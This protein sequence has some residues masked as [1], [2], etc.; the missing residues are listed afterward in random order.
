MSYKQFISG[1]CPLKQYEREIQVTVS[2]VSAVGS[3]CCQKRITEFQCPDGVTC[4]YR[5]G[6]QFCDLVNKL[7]L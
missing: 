7:H 4:P 3:N 6:H 2:E 5:Q 1:Y